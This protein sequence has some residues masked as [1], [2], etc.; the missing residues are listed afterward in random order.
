MEYIQMSLERYERL[1][2]FE[3]ENI[4][5][6]NGLESFRI[7]GDWVDDRSRY[8]HT[9]YYNK[10]DMTTILVDEVKMLKNSEDILTKEIDKLESK[11]I[12]S[13]FE[14]GAEKTFKNNLKKWWMLWE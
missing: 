3:K 9:Y 12:R 6:K 2:A 8:V 4:R 7:L 13:Q 11:L 1:I 5:L 10:T 14:L